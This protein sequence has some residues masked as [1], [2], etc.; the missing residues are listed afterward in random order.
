MTGTFGFSYVGLIFLA[1][2]FIPNILYARVPP[3]DA[4]KFEENKV[5]LAC[6]RAGQALC[7]VTVLIFS[8]FNVHSVDPRLLWLGGALVLMLLYLIC[9]GRY[10]AG[11]HV[12]R[13]FLRP[14]L[15]LPLPL[16]VLPVAAALL[17]AVY[18]RVIWLGIA[19]VILGVGHIGI[20][21][22]HWAALKKV[23]R[24]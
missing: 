21:A 8:D 20:T 1:C 4:V 19:G 14:F 16:A 22:Q 3:T 12:T 24:P 7:T 11:K 10:F 13:D 17:L 15:G 2:L 5:L 23:E 6:E 18:G 9:W